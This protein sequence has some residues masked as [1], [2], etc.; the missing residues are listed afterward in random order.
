MVLA[1][2]S[3]EESV[4]RQELNKHNVLTLGSR[5]LECLDFL[6]PLQLFSTTTNLTYF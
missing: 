1:R 3:G 5:S 6:F 4:S 2:F